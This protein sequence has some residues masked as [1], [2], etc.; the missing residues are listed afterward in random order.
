MSRRKTHEEFLL[1]L[2][3]KNPVVEPIDEY[4]NN[5]TNIRFRCK[6]C[7]TIWRAIPDNILVGRMCPNC[8]IKSRTKKRRKSNE[9]FAKQM[10]ELH[11]DL[12][13][14]DE[15][16]NNAT[17]VTCVC[18]ICGETEKFLPTNLI[19]G[20][21]CRFCAA[22]KRGLSRRKTHE[23]FVREMSERH[24]DIKVISKY[25]KNHTKMQFECMKCHHRWFSTP[26]NV[27]NIRGCPS[28]SLPRG[29]H[30]IDIYLT[31]HGV[32]HTHQYTSNGLVGP[33]GG[34]LSYDFYLPDNNILIEYQ[35]EYHD[36]TAKNQ[37]LLQFEIQREC[38]RRKAEYAKE[39]NITLLEI[40]YYEFEDIEKILTEKLL[41]SPLTITA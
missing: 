17:P 24:K 12:I 6:T 13:L 16:L 41:Q 23:Q 35:G 25:E 29:E 2:K 14:I 20:K 26:C 40:W 18:T 4:I 30:A 8:A 11:P 1:E 15:Y 28:C 5:R 36:G 31:E 39:N 21:G 7:G 22:T 34:E 27:M 3:V 37:T 9:D 32:R 38:D 19:S 10:D 33:R